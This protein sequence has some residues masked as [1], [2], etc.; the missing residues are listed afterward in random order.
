M[1]LL[2]INILKAISF[3]IGMT[4]L[5]KEIVKIIDCITSDR[6]RTIYFLRITIPW[7]IFYF[8]HLL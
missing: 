6:T 8:L 3:L 1:Y 2:I 4:T 5:L 7:T